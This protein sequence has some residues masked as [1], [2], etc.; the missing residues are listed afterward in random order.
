MEEIMEKYLSL[1]SRTSYRILCDRKDSEFVTVTLFVRLSKRTGSFREGVS[2][3]Q[4]LREACRLCRRRLIRRRLLSLLS[5]GPEVYVINTPTVPTAEAYVARQAWEVFCRAAR[6]C[7]GRDLVVYA[8]CELEGLSYPE[9][10][11]ICRYP[12]RS[13][14]MS[15]RNVRFKV[16]EELDHYGRISDYNAYIGFIRKVKDQLTDEVVLQRKILKSCI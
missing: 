2:E 13:I 7:A 16:M 8:L 4:I 9:A 1:V 12:L 10:S 6:N 11:S 3:Q 14:E 15:I 5:I